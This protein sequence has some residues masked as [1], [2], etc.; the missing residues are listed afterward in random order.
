[1]KYSSTKMAPKGRIPVSR[2]DGIVR[3]LPDIG[4]TCRYQ[5][6]LERGRQLVGIQAIGTVKIP[7]PISRHSSD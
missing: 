5:R 7:P 6:A 3:R 1:M 4:G 2:I